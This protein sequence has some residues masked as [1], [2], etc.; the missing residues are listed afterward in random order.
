[1]I[2]PCVVVRQ[3]VRAAGTADEDELGGERSYARQLLKVLEPVLVGH[4]PKSITRERVVLGSARKRAEL[5]DLA[6][7]QSRL[8]CGELSEQCRRG[9]RPGFAELITQTLLDCGGLRHPDPLPD[10]RPGCGL[11][12]GVEQNRSQSRKPSLQ[13]SDNTVAFAEG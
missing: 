8:G 4:G 9:K 2:E 13:C 6:V 7:G 5:T 11:I 10:D 3:C 1:V 12:W